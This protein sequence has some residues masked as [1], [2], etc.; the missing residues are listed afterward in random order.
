MGTA[1]WA[2]VRRNV[3]LLCDI[4][5]IGW[6]K[7]LAKIWSSLTNGPLRATPHEP[8]RTI[9]LL[10]ARDADAVSLLLADAVEKLA[11]V[12]GGKRG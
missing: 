4:L 1:R 3:S 7:Y 11:D 2:G 12:A 9:M 8:R 10:G 5:C 6:G